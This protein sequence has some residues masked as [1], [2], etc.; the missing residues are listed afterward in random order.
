MERGDTRWWQ[1]CQ[2]KQSKT[3]REDK[4]SSSTTTTTDD[5]KVPTLPVTTA[6]KALLIEIGSEMIRSVMESAKSRNGLQRL[7]QHCSG[8]YQHQNRKGSGSA[9]GSRTKNIRPYTRGRIQHTFASML[10]DLRRM[11]VDIQ[12]SLIASGS[13]DKIRSYGVRRKFQMVP[14]A[15]V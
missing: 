12:F 6:K 9:K 1:R 15:T 14:V 5:S 11:P 8:G 13:Y 7:Q 3:L 10:P 4:C 2:P